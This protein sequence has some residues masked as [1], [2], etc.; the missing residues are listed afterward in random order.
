MDVQAASSASAVQLQVQYQARVL[1]MQKNAMK[2]AGD[3]VLQLLQAAT[4]V[5][6]AQGQHLNVKA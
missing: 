1:S 3:N 2:A 5:D 6:P 4:V